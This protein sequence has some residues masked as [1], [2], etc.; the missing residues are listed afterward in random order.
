MKRLALIVAVGILLA[1]VLAC[2]LPGQTTAGGVVV[3]LAPAPGATWDQASLLKARDIIRIR[4]GYTSYF[5][6]PVQALPE[7]KIQIT[8]PGG[9]DVQS[10]VA[11]AS[12][13][14]A[15][16][17]YDS[18]ESLPTGSK[19][20]ETLSLILTETD[21]KTVKAE[22]DNTTQKWFIAFTLTPD[23]AQKL[24]DYS[25]KNIGRYLVIAVDGI[26]IS[27]PTIQSQITGGKGVIQGQFD[28]TS[29]QDL[30]NIFKGGRL[31][32]P[33]VVVSTSTK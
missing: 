2:T 20:P 5:F 26:V 18:A 30:A 17:L 19:I 28:Q 12:Q 9:V 22:Q 11:T 3:I 33:V 16:G 14:G 23:G 6:N 10:Q 4:L 25:G 27:S 7:G 15:V 31:P 1:S 13:F 21:F 29:A 24:S 8:L 32:F